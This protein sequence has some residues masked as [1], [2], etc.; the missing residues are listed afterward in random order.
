MFECYPSAP[1][2]FKYGFMYSV[3]DDSDN[4]ISHGH[5]EEEA[6][7]PF[8]INDHM[9]EVRWKS[10]P[11]GIVVDAG[12]SFAYQTWMEFSNPSQVACYMSECE[13]YTKV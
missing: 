12:Q 1:C 5:F 10:L 3:K 4:I 13:D 7:G 11:G 9:I 8:A 6:K 2:S